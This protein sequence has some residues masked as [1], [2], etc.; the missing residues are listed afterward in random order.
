M[1]EMIGDLLSKIMKA[2]NSVCLFKIPFTTALY[3]YNTIIGHVFF[4]RGAVIPHVRIHLKIPLSI[5]NPDYLSQ[6]GKKTN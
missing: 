1:T 3:H 2:G 6:M 4:L 5:E